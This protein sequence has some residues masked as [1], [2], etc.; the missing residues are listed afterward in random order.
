MAGWYPILIDLQGRTCV[1]VGGGAVAERK[2]RG[3]LE[4]GALVRVVSPSLTA[5]L[6]ELASEGA[7]VTIDREYRDGDLAEAALA[8]AATDHPEAN[9]AVVREA[10]NRGVPANAADGGTEG[11]FIVPAVVRRGDLL[12]TASASGA[13]PA[14]AARIA[15]ELAGRYGPE[16]GSYLKALR[17][18]RKVVK[19][20][21][22]DPATRRK[23][24]AAASSEDAL[25]EWAGIDAEALDASELLERL[26]VRALGGKE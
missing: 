14:V 6:A 11:D 8:F 22:A 7:I 5:G 19:A 17:H 24:L 9:A 25:A 15:G 16:Y 10:R 4:A 21:V 2:T 12:L 26:R 23:L 3:L 1:V 18:I 13:G 20:E